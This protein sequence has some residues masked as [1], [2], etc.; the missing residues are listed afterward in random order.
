MAGSV[1]LISIISG[2]VLGIVLTILL[3]KYSPKII[4][5]IKLGRQSQKSPKGDLKDPDRLIRIHLLKKAQRQHLAPELCS[6][7]DIYID[8][9][10]YSHPFHANPVMLQDDDPL[11]FRQALSIID[12]P[13]LACELPLPR[14]TLS[15][16]LAGGK[17]IAIAGGIGTG[18]T[19]CMANFAIE[20][21]ESRCQN[22]SFNDFL[23]LLFHISQVTFY[24]N[25]TLVEMLSRCL[26]DEGID[27]TPPEIEKILTGYDAKSRLLVLIDGLDELRPTEFS[28]A[29]KILHRIHKENPRVR[30]ISTCG[31]YFTGELETAGFSILHLIPPSR[32]EFNNLI[33]SWL[34]VWERIRPGDQLK[35]SQEVESELIRL[36]VNQQTIRTTFSKFTY[37]ILSV[38]FHDLVPDEQPIIPLLARKTDGRVTLDTLVRLSRF[39]ARSGSF[40][41]TYKDTEVFLSTI[42]S[43]AGS[44][45]S[46]LIDL[47][48]QV[49]IFTDFNEHLRFTNP[50]VMANLLSISE[51]IPRDPDLAILL[52]SP[53]DNYITHESKNDPAYITKWI[54]S[55]DPLDNR[56]IAITLDHLFSRSVA[57]S[58]INLSFPKLAR[59]VVS[60]QLPLST[61]IKFAAMI[62]YAN[63]SVFSQLLTKLES[64]QEKDC[65]KL[66]AFFYGLSS[67]VN[68]ETFIVDTIENNEVSTS[69]FGFIALLISTDLNAM[70]L[71]RNLVQSDPE[72]YGRV[73]SELCSQYPKS[74]YNFIRELSSNENTV[75]RRFSLY[76]LRL[77]QDEWAGKLLDEI[78]RNDKAW[79]IRD[80]AAHALNNKYRPEIYAPTRLPKITD[81]SVIIAYASKNGV[82][83][84]LNAYPYDLLFA[85]LENGTLNEKIQAI[86]YL[87]ARPNEVV[88]NK[89]KR[90]IIY[91]NPVREIAS[92]ALFEISLRF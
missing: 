53:V 64:V 47:F 12:V 48:L 4:K 41:Q 38:L 33:S 90:L 35:K 65:R 50:S 77:V 31:P 44:K 46:V 88:I 57:P 42:P 6:L 81:N 13:D 79:I 39:F 3:I 20:I 1:D 17:N 5:L 69:L 80:A 74:G 70:E 91:E 26:Y 34:H 71:L 14:I 49:E 15:Q 32:T 8:Q 27:Q 60:E 72:R 19:A 55:I 68:H 92:R 51:T 25:L 82:G 21:L 75:L 66:C 28:A 61:K 43:L 24:E 84:P 67:L 30:L 11:F 7:S 22:E 87:A 29:V 62:N 76:G 78:S 16:A 10:F 37:L 52:R 36:W 59:Y 45:S 83:I 63:P 85:I 89:I 86:Q 54:D 23:P 2:I 18:K 56:S 40:I 73:V 58:N 9:F